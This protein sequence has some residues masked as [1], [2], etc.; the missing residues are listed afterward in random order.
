MLQIRDIDCYCGEAQVLKSFSLAAERGEILCLLGRNGAGKTTAL[1]A[2]M[3]LVRSRRGSIMFVKALERDR[4]VAHVD[5]QRLEARGHAIPIV[6]CRLQRR[7]DV[8]RVGIIS[9][10]V[11]HDDKAA[12]AA[13]FE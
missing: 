9:E 5:R 13:R 6:E 12:I 11:R 1:K 7:H 8:R 2:I 3:G 10:V 4:I